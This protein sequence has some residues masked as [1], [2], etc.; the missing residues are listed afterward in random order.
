MTAT[1]RKTGQ[2]RNTGHEKGA[3]NPFFMPKMFFP[4]NFFVY[5]AENE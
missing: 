5:S 4:N 3:N 2:N 1:N